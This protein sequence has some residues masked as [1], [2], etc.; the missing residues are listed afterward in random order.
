M[1]ACGG[2]AEAEK[3]KDDEKEGNDDVESGRPGGLG[4]AEMRAEKRRQRCQV[5]VG[6][7]HDG[8]DT[9]ALSRKKDAA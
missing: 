6:R 1:G 8:T 3:K 7:L 2:L 4:R 9:A 5:E